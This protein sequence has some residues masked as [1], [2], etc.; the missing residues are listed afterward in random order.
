MLWGVL[1]TLATDEHE[2]CIKMFARENIVMQ[3]TTTAR[4]SH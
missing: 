4:I 3:K 2:P 1:A